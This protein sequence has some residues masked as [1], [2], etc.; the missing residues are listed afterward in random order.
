MAQLLSLLAT[1]TEDYLVPSTCN[2][3]SK[4]SCALFWTLW[5]SAHTCIYLHRNTHIQIV[6]INILRHRQTMN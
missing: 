5:V 6:K 1:L 2:S 4:G 3:S